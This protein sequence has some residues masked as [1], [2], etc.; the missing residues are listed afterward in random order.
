[1]SIE[2]VLGEMTERQLM[3]LDV[4]KSMCLELSRLSHDSKM[5]VAT[6]IITDDFREVCA[7]GYNGNYKGGPNERESME[8]GQSGFLHSEEN[9]LFHLSK[10]FE[11]RNKLIMICTHKPCPMCAK[12]I[13]N[14]E[15][16]RV[17]Y[18]EDYCGLGN[19]TDE[20][21]LNGGVRC[22]KI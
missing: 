16:K 6:I 9:A 7:I 8:T 4:F 15:I 3:K 22:S 2:D 21:F 1:M 13:V 14:S 19:S 10:S 11:L 12:R 20:I 18:V 5:K 17:L